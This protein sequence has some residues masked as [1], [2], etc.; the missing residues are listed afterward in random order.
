[1]DRAPGCASRPHRRARRPARYAPM[2]PVFGPVSPSPRRLWS[3][4]AGS[5]RI[6]L[7][8]AQREDARLAALEPLLDDDPAARLAK[9]LIDQAVPDRCSA[10]AMSPHTVT[11][12]PPARP[13]A[14]TTT[15]PAR[16][17][18]K[19][20]AAAASVERRRPRW[21]SHARRSHTS[22]AEDLLPSRRAAAA[23]G[24]KTG[25]AGRAQ[26]IG[27]A[28][29]ERVLRPDHDQV[30]RLA[31]ARPTMAVDIGDA[32]AGRPSRRRS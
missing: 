3:R 8:V 2:P 28:G 27:E 23:L 15:R 11:P 24:P 29:H 25:D 9:A 6:A 4:A 5:S 13:S 26:T 20:S 22:R 16:A 10:S 18:A 31:P 21:P 1:M 30:D 7:A 32:T 17:R 14:L 12:L 19:S